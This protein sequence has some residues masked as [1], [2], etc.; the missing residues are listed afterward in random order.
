MRPQLSACSCFLSLTVQILTLH[1]NPITP[2]NWIG[3]VRCSDRIKASIPPTQ[4]GREP[5]GPQRS[6]LEDWTSGS[7][8]TINR[9]GK[10]GPETCR[11]L[12]TATLNGNCG[13]VPT[14]IYFSCLCTS[15]T[16]GIKRSSPMIAA[17]CEFLMTL[18][19]IFSARTA[20]PRDRV[21][22]LSNKKRE[23]RNENMKHSKAKEYYLK[24][25]ILN[26]LT[27]LF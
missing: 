22:S 14:S 6:I 21:L 3:C 9:R 10:K 8:G 27:G 4:R 23:E 19:F 11:W 16:N 5:C 24:C 15:A 13:N 2:P 1:S 18:T 20:Q 7:S 26:L 17:H 25:D 12:H